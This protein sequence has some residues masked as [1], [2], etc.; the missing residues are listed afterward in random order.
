MG[1]SDGVTLQLCTDEKTIKRTLPT[2]LSGPN[3]TWGPAASAGPSSGTI[4]DTQ[5]SRGPTW[6]PCG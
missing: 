2:D 1:D 4:L 6:C 3:L 5:Q